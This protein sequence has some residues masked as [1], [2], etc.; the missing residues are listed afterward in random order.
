MQFSKH[1]STPMRLMRGSRVCLEWFRCYWSSWL[2]LCSRGVCLTAATM[3]VSSRKL[4]LL[5]SFDPLKEETLFH[6]LPMVPAPWHLRPRAIGFPGFPA[7]SGD[8]VIG[9]QQMEGRQSDLQS[10]YASWQCQPYSCLIPGHLTIHSATCHNVRCPMEA[11]PPTQGTNL[12]GTEG[13][14]PAAW[15]GLN[16][17][18]DHSMLGPPPQPCLPDTS[19]WLLP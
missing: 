12:W 16:L 1:S 7:S 15:E 8:L 19:S 17:N 5:S 3:S 14:R 13:L 6:C 2:A 18:Q 4:R 10:G 9:F 11:L